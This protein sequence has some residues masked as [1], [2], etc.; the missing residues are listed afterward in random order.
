MWVAFLWLSPLVIC[1]S[2]SPALVTLQP[3]D[4]HFEKA[5]RTLWLTVS[6]AAGL[7][8]TNVEV[9]VVV[10]VATVPVVSALLTV[11]WLTVTADSSSSRRPGGSR[12]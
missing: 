3:S 12:L 4:A 1:S 9:A 5:G 8:S 11:T 7:A 10:V 6:E 2:L